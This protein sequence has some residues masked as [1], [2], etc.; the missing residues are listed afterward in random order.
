LDFARGMALKGLIQT[1]ASIN[2]GNSGGP[3]L[4]VLGE[5]IG[6]NTAIR[7]DAQNI[8]FAIPV[9]RLREVLPDLLDIER[10]YRITCGISLDTLETPRVTSVQAGSPAADAGVMVG[11][12]VQSVDGRSIHEGIEFS[13]ALIG[14]KAGQPLTLGIVREGDMKEVKLTLAAKPAPDGAKLAQVRLGMDIA[15]LPADSA[16]AVGLP[17]PPGGGPS[18]V[19]VSGVEPRGPADS[20]GLQR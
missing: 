14:R 2:P 12:I 18:G 4:N 6:V 8:G 15:D 9:D 11:D 3:L 17:S 13:I 7:G 10:R 5:L 20:A 19:Y 16:A 1:D